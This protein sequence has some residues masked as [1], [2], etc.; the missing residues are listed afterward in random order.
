MRALFL[1]V[2]S[3]GL[4]LCNTFKIYIKPNIM[5]YILPLLVSS[6]LAIVISSGRIKERRCFNVYIC[7][8]SL[9]LVVQSYFSWKNIEKS[10]VIESS[11]AE[12]SGVIFTCILSKIFI[13]TRITKLRVLAMIIITFG[14]L[15]PLLFNKENTNIHFSIVAKH[16]FCSLL[17]SV[18]NILYDMK[19]KPKMQTIM[20]FLFM[21][22][23]WCLILSTLVFIFDVFS[24][25]IALY[26][27]LKD[28]KAYAVVLLESGSIFMNYGL[29]FCL[30]P[31]ERTLL[32]LLINLSAGM[33]EGV[34]LKRNIRI[35][36][37]SSLCIVGFGV[38]VYNIEYARQVLKRL[39]MRI[40]D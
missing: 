4:V 37:A 29:V 38:I 22:S 3:V 17:F 26:G 21:S 33:I 12:P 5:P 31:I 2:A 18:I 11:L 1:S 20:H 27:V 19:I 6:L 28:K 14:I 40:K 34:I 36:D 35:S 15:L 25:E 24:R 13:K 23:F 16:I 39:R 32:K 7:L 8:A 30:K 9:L 10:K